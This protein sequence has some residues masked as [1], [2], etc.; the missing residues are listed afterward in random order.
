MQVEDDLVQILAGICSVLR[1]ANCALVGGHTSEGSEYSVGLTINGTV[2]QSEILCKGPPVCGDVLILT[3]AIGTGAILAADM[4][5]AA[6]GKWV[7]A[8]VTSMLQSNQN[9]AKILYKHGCSACTDVTGF[10]LIGHLLEM[11]KYNRNYDTCSTNTSTANSFES[12]CRVTIDMKKIPILLGAED[13]VTAD[14]VSSLQHQ[15]SFVRLY[16]RCNYNNV[17]LYSLILRR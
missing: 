13:C 3:K 7:D 6:K 11:M 4:R 8:A 15:V 14:I 16:F 9:A 12:L 1:T 2:R 17:N 10:G 5:A